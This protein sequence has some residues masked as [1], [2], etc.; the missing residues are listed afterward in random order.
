M[1]TID[2]LVVSLSPHLIATA[3]RISARLG[4]RRADQRN[5]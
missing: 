5:N 1:I 3:A 4:Y 2:E